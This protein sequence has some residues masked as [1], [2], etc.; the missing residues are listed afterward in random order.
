MSC[1]LSFSIL[2]KKLV[3]SFSGDEDKEPITKSPIT[4]QVSPVSHLYSNITRF[5]LDFPFKDDIAT[6]AA[7]NLID[8]ISYFEYLEQTSFYSKIHVAF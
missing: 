1:P 6:S 5:I 4:G 2:A 3:F 8:K 7:S